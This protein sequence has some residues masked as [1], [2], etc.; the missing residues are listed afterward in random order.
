MPTMPTNSVSGCPPTVQR[1]ANAITSAA[2]RARGS[3]T[4][5]MAAAAKPG[6]SAKTLLCGQSS[7]TMV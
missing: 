1:A 5:R 6:S 3:F 7:Q 4:R 2:L